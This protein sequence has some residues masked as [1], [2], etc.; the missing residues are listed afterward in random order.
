MGG[1]NFFLG[2]PL[3]MSTDPT[4]SFKSNWTVQKTKT[5]I[6]HQLNGYGI[7]SLSGRRGEGRICHD[8]LH[9]A[10]HTGLHHLYR[11]FSIP[12]RPA[13]TVDECNTNR[14]LPEHCS[15]CN[16]GMLQ[17]VHLDWCIYLDSIVDLF[18][19]HD[20]LLVYCISAIQNLISGSIIL[21]FIKGTPC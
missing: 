20:D 11:W 3:P 14:F 1:H 21:R 15:H 13:N 4:N 6:Q 7:F 9:N 12:R 10:H 19:Q 17:R 5:F 8:G 2:C 16:L 18:R